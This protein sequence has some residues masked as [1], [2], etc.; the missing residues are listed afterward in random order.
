VI[1]TCPKLKRGYRTREAAEQALRVMRQNRKLSARRAYQCP[2]CD[3][4]HL[5]S[6][7]RGYE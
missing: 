1:S 3:Q 2:W 7:A 6:K 4:W 5:T